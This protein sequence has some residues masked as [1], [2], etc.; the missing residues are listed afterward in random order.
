VDTAA[1][2]GNG[3]NSKD[4]VPND[5][6]VDEGQRPETVTV[7]PAAIAYETNGDAVINDC[8]VDDG[9]RASVVRNAA[10]NDEGP[11]AEDSSSVIANDTITNG[12][13][14]A[15][16]R[17]AAP[18]SGE[19]MGDSKPRDSR[20]HRDRKNALHREHALGIAAA[21]GDDVRPRPG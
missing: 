9:K 5:G 11:E 13:C 3:G 8:G 4:L 12:Q 21:D 7:N 20:C 17:D 15:Q 2:S 1:D 19:A 14:A 18:R 10:P 16:L 6:G